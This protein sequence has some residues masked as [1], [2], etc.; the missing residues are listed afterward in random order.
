MGTVDD[1]IRAVEAAAATMVTPAL[2]AWTQ[3]MGDTFGGIAT[4][5]CKFPPD[6]ELSWPA[7]LAVTQYGSDPRRWPGIFS[8][9]DRHEAEAWLRIGPP[10]PIRHFPLNRHR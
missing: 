7:A 9:K 1:A 8:E 3:A 5:P 4:V 6:L 10:P 2:L